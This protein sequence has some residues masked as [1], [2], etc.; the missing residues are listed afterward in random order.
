MDGAQDLVSGVAAISEVSPGVTYA[1]LRQI[2]VNGAD[3]LGVPIAKIHD[4]NTGR[5]RLR[6]VNAG[7]HYGFVVT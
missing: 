2:V 4:F 3:P 5:R 1:V 6:D 7:L